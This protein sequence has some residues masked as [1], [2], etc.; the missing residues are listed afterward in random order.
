MQ[1]CT[2]ALTVPVSVIRVHLTLNWIALKIEEE[3]E[4]VPS[5]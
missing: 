5:L 2:V 1:I 3:L 4:T